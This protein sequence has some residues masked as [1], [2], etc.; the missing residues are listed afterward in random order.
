[1]FLVLLSILPEMADCNSMND[2]WFLWNLFLVPWCQ[3]FNVHC[4]DPDVCVF[5][6]Q[7]TVF[8]FLETEIRAVP[9]MGKT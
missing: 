1:M 6:K 8:M 7:Q 5:S 3:D 2:T 4:V 9:V